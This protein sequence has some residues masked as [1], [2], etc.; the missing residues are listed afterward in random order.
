MSS[1]P[2]VTGGALWNSANKH[3]VYE[4]PFDPNNCAPWVMVSDNEYFRNY[5][6]IR[7]DGSIMRKTE[8][9]NVWKMIED[10]KRELNDNAGR[11]WGDGKSFFRCP[12]NLYF[13]LGLG[14]ANKQGDRKYQRKI[15]NDPDYRDFRIFP[16]RI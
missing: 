1:K 5:E 3:T 7:P 11:K 15:W 12:M 8:N 10:N 14:E 9:K 13:S 2:V 4:E 6:L 16:G